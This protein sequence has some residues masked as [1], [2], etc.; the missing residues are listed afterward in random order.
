MIRRDGAMESVWQGIAAYQPVNQTARTRFDVAVIGG[1]ITG[2]TTALALQESGKQCVLLEAETLCY[3]T[4]GGTTA[5]L[6]T[7]LD[8]PYHAINSNFG[9][10]E[11]RQVAAAVRKAIDRIRNTVAR[12]GI[13]CHFTDREAYIFSRNKEQS[14]ELTK[15]L[16]SAIAAGLDVAWAETNHVP[17]PFEKAIAVAAQ[18]S[19]HPLMY[20]NALAA[21]F[22]EK[23]G[24][25]IQ[26]C[27]VTGVKGDSLLSIA[28]SRLHNLEAAFVVFATHIPTGVNLLHL[29]CAPYRSYAMA[30]TLKDQSAYPRALVYDSDDPY[31]YFRTE[32]SNGRQYLVAGGEDHK[33]GHG[34]HMAGHFQQL[35]AFVRSY[36]P[37]E[38]IAYRWSSQYYEPADGLPYIGRLPGH[39]DNVFVATGFS[40]NGM[41]YSQVA[42][43]CFEQLLSGKEHPYPFLEPNRVK[44]VAGFTQFVGHNAGVAAELVKR[45]IP[46]D[47]LS[48]LADLAKDEARIVRF[49]K[50]TAA[51]FR[52]AAGAIHA[53]DPACTHMKCHVHWNDAEK[54]WD[55]PCHGAR[56]DVDGKVLNS[57]ADR[58][59]QQ[60]RLPDVD[61]TGKQ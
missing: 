34:N 20:C 40:G 5:H 59:L 50:E 23:G 13:D 57:P 48:S 7:L 29:R 9:H 38:E 14:A 24:I 19:F 56:F 25:I 52:D 28:T 37:V 36:F 2:L 18:A 47:K 58:D 42:A 17:I 33:T 46:A 39:G 15:T 49:D 54:S 53:V 4:T 26:Q 31:H 35:E 30:L 51:I 44:P 45:L 10:D 21:A 16:E 61:A 60:F 6:N 41:V 1:G 3:G 55:C 27:R 22:E 11:A 12:Y 8:T 32:T 43:E